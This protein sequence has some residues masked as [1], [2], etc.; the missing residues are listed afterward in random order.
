MK[1]IASTAIREYR[2]KVTSLYQKIVMC[3]ELMANLHR[4]WFSGE[5]K[6]DAF[7]FILMDERSAHKL[8]RCI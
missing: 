1:A 3:R 2:N 6:S 7:F 4:L 5:K 8:A